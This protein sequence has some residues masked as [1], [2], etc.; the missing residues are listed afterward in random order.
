[1]FVNVVVVVVFVVVV[2]VVFVNVSAASPRCGVKTCMT[3]NICFRHSLRSVVISFSTVESGSKTVNVLQCL[4]NYLMNSN[5]VEISLI[6]IA[7]TERNM[8]ENVLQ[9]GGI[10]VQIHV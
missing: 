8:I 10:L 1:M 5:I 6:D 9:Y 7:C 4:M 3:R 2:N